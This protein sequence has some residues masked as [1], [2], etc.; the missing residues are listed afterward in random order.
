MVPG[1]TEREIHAHDL[2]RRDWLDGE[3]RRR[4]P[5]QVKSEPVGETWLA[6]ARALLSWVGT[7]LSALIPIR[8]SRVARPSLDMG[9][10]PG[11]ASATGWLRRR[12]G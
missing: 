11:V 12:G 4:T 8:A 9:A 5:V 1:M 7:R 2:I 3:R 10:E 6:T